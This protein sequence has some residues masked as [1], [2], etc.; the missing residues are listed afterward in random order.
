LSA[1]AALADAGA[2]GSGATGASHDF[3]QHAPAQVPQQDSAPLTAGADHTPAWLASSSSAVRMAMTVL[4]EKQLP[5]WTPR[6]Q[7]RF[8][9]N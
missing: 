6:G 5:Q 9:I 3:T 1:G 8:N 7:Q 4:T 2:S